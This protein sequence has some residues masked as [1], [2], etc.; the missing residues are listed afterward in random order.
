MTDF[1]DLA[2]LTVHDFSPLLDQRFDLLLADGPVQLR[3]VEAKPLHRVPG[4][5]DQFSLIF[6]SADQR[7]LPQGTYALEHARAN[8]LALFIV[9]VARDAEGVSYQAVFA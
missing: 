7:V 5:R 4:G 8:G 6:K 2:S 1:T 3:L 9:A